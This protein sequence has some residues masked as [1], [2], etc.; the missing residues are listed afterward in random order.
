MAGSGATGTT[1][2]T[3]VSGINAANYAQDLSGAQLAAAGAGA[4]IPIG[5]YAGSNATD[6]VGANVGQSGAPVYANIFG[7]LAQGDSQGFKQVPAGTELYVPAAFKNLIQG[8][9]ALSSG[10]PATL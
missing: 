6:F 7:G 1:A 10:A 2:A 5:Y 9:P 3:P 8:T 4:Y